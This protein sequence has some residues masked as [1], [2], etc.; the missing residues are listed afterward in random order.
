MNNNYNLTEEIKNQ[1]KEQTFKN[2]IIKGTNKKDKSIEII[3]KS[4]I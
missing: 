1:N 3:K 4:K 2:N